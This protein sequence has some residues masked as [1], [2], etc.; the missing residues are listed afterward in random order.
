MYTLTSLIWPSLQQTFSSVLLTHHTLYHWQEFT[1]F[2]LCCSHFQGVK[3]SQCR[4][5]Q[6]GYVVVFHPNSLKMATCHVWGGP[7]TFGNFNESLFCLEKVQNFIA[8]QRTKQ[9][10]TCIFTHGEDWTSGERN[11]TKA[12]LE[13]RRKQVLTYEHLFLVITKDPVLHPLKI[14]AK[15]EVFS[16]WP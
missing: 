5:E 1:S 11:Q 2:N 7:H 13:S 15:K 10:P 16:Q 4:C 9:A 14:K 12:K 8:K 3:R 6:I